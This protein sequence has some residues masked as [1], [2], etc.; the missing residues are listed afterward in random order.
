MNRFDNATYD[1]DTIMSQNA[2]KNLCQQ[3]EVFMD[4]IPDGRSKSM[5]LTKLEECYMWIGKGLRDKQWAKDAKFK[6]T[7]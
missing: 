4:T 1:N 3:L 6:E 5:A 7:L 2:F